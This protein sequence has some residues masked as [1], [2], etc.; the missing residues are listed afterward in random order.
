[1]KFRNK[2]L[3]SILGIVFLLVVVTYFVVTSITRNRII[4]T[5][6]GELRSNR[7]TVSIF[8]DLRSEDGMNSC[9]VISESPRLKAVTEIGDSVT[10]Y[11]L[12]LDLYQNIGADIFILT[13]EEGRP[14]IELFRGN[15]AQLAHILE[16]QI[17]RA[18]S[19]TPGATTVVHDRELYRLATAPILIDTEV[20]GSLT[21]GFEIPGDEIAQLGRM[22]NSDIA[23]VAGPGVL[24]AP[25]PITPA[26]EHLI[27][28][29]SRAETISELHLDGSIH[30]GQATRLDRSSDENDGVYYLLLKSVEKE[31]AASLAPVRRAFLI[32]ALCVLV[33]TAVTGSIIARGISK[34]IEKLVGAASRIRE[35]AYGYLSNIT[36]KNELGLLSRT[37]DEMSISL[38][39]KI[40]ELAKLNA[41][42]RDRNERLERT[43]EELRKTQEDLVKSERLAAT[44]KL[45]AQLSHEINNPIHNI[46][47]CLETAIRKTRSSSPVKELLDVA[48][49]EVTR[50]SQLTRQLLDFHRT[51]VIDETRSCVDLRDIIEQTVKISKETLE[52]SDIR[53]VQHPYREGLPVL[54]SPEKIK[55]VVFNIILNARDAMPTGGEIRITSFRKNGNAC[56]SICDTGT[57]ITSENKSKIFDAF[58][59][60]KSLVRGV[61]LGLSVSYAIVQ[62]HNGTIAVESEQNTGSTFTVSLP[63]H[64][65]G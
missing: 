19:L 44:G 38:K 63:L 49:E 33:A 35:G 22:T 42:L 10:A 60:T 41:D 52:K 59:T 26:N 65:T 24:Y 32:I 34:P 5:F 57:G 17:R 16:E 46:Q 54:C 9:L 27:L 64:T 18:I 1:M 15:V 55:Q 30:L 12:M 47:S 56:V 53:L 40:G 7:L 39:D 43:L 28:T 11:R 6:S 48:Y 58:F 61:G 8:N 51:S 25:V 29:A 21:L 14:M 3:A 20:L 62:Q 36:E 4:E 37:F 13:D 23:I 31:L 45:S 2:I 50:M